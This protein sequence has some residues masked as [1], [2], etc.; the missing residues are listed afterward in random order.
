MK[1]SN[2]LITKSEIIDSI[3]EFFVFRSFEEVETPQVITGPVP[4][5]HI[6]LFQVDNGYLRPSPEIEMKILLSE[7]AEKIFQIGPCFRKDEIGR[8]HREEFTMLEWYETNADYTTLLDFTKDMLVYLANN[9]FKSSSILYNGDRIDFNTP[10]MIMTV[11]DAFAKFAKLTP[12]EAISQNRFEEILVDKIEPN[13]PTGLPVI[14]KDFPEKFA[15]LAKLKKDDMSVSERWE[16]YIGGIEIANTYSELIDPKQNRKRFAKFAEERKLMEKEEIPV[17]EKFFKSLEKG[18]PNCSGCALG[19][20]RL[21]MVL[22][23]LNNIE[24]VV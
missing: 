15:A 18:I 10:L 13:F 17:N 20:E 12:E 19:I 6:D 14:L 23:D 24:D 11:N 5:P 4:E 8:L 1:S 3:R 16:L 2:T 22:N 21:A 7:G 9:F